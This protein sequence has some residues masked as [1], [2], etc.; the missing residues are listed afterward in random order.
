MNDT[1]KFSATPHSDNSS[2]S[3]RRDN[4]NA[5]Q[6]EM[7]RHIGEDLAMSG[8][9]F[10][11]QFLDPSRMT[12]WGKHYPASFWTENA[13][14]DWKES[15]APFHSVGRLT[16]LAKSQLS[17]DEAALVSFD[18]TGN[19]T[20]DS[21]PLGSINRARQ[22]GELASRNARLGQAKVVA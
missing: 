7:S 6:E 11:V 2:Q 15:Q 18:V 3:L 19:A 10:G 5:L 8:F 21:T 16:I 22:R 17:T 12:Y 13:S 20:A 1:V 9:D 4:P 14:I